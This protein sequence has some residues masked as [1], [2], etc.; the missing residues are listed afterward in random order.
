MR[1]HS[2]N[3]IRLQLATSTERTFIG[4]AAAALIVTISACGTKENA[5]TESAGVATSAIA[6]TADPDHEFLRMMTDHHKGMILM[7]HET[8]ESKVKLGV[9]PIAARL[10]KEQDAEMDQMTTMLEQQ[11]RDPY[12]PKVTADNQEMADQLKGKSRSEYDRTFLENVIR[13]HEQAVKMIDAY[14]PIAKMPELKKMA[15]K[16]KAVQSAEIAEFKKRLTK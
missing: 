11:F 7:A 1:Y 9:K 5:K 3:C 4:I 8:I 14:L 13:H 10:D 6:V 2:T 12:A 15:E 16:M